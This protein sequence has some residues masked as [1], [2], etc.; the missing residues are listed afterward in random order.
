VTT[1]LQ[2]SEADFLRWVKDVAKLF[3]WRYSH[4][5]PAKTA[6]G[7]RTALEGDRGF[8]DLVLVRPPRVIFAEL[9]SD[10]GKP[11]AEQTSWLSDLTAS[12]VE[13]YTWHP[14]DQPEVMLTLARLPK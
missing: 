2:V 4:F 14:A 7:W 10:D 5:R 13:V 9:K 1:R 6:K 12:S 11:T 8:P 3:G